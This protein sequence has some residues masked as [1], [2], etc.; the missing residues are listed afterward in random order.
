MLRFSMTVPIEAVSVWM[1]GASPTTCTVS[2]SA[3]ISRVS[4]TR[5]AL[6]TCTSRFAR[7]IA[8]NPESSAFKEYTPGCKAG[9]TY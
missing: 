6:P 2:F 1:S 5:I 4:G 8:R 7:S 3:P 9:I